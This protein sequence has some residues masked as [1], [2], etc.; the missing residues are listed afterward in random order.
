MKTKDIL[1][2]VVVMSTLLVGCENLGEWDQQPADNAITFS[3][4][5]SMLS[6]RTLVTSENVNSGTAPVYVAAVVGKDRLYPVDT[7]NSKGEQITRNTTTN[8]WSPKTTNNTKNWENDKEY[9][10]NAF[11]Y[12]P[13]TA[14]SDGSLSFASNTYGW[15][16][17]VT[18][19]NTYT[20]DKMV[21]Y[22]YS[23]TFKCNGTTRPIV[24]LDLQHALSLVEVR[25]AKHESIEEAYLE[26]VTLNG[27]Y[28]T[29]NME[30][31][32]ATYMSGANNEW[33]VSFP[34]GAT[35]DTSY[36]VSGG[37]PTKTSSGLI[38][39]T[40][41]E[42]AGSIVL[43]FIA[44]PQQM[45]SSVKLLVSYWVNEKFNSSS[46]DN[47]KQHT[48][49]FQLYNYSPNSWAS[50]H[51]ITYSLVV[52]TGIHLEGVIRDWIETD[53]IE[54]TVLPDVE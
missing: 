14:T 29:A 7:K 18:Q 49:E 12:L 46:A 45:D 1:R 31:S 11:S 42:D 41:R 30:C 9:S 44:V 4:E 39:L 28:R 40:V 27:F 47:F 43:S 50:G 17:T 48:A 20:P 2:V 23:H 35:K 16:I 8:K 3:L 52:D 10:F 15:G 19:P 36:S 24:K 25:I 21:D 34:S 13:T 26:K 5:N 51:R 32:A 53:Y 54:G 38:P 6:L 22:L 33:R 37:D